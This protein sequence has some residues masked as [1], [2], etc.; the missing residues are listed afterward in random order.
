MY[1]PYKQKIDMDTKLL[2]SKLE[3]IQNDLRTKASSDE[4]RE[5]LTDLREK[6]ERIST[7]ETKVDELTKSVE[8]RDATVLELQKRLSILEDRSVDNARRNSELEHISHLRGRKVDDQEQ[9][10]RKVNLRIKGIPIKE[11]ET[12]TSLL[13]IVKAEC[14]R[15]GVGVVSGD[16]DHCHRNGK[17]LKDGN[18]SILLK[19][20]SWAARNQIYQ[21]RKEFNFK[22]SH[23][24]TARRQQLFTKA[25]E[26]LESDET[27]KKVVEYP[28]AD[29]NCKLKLK[30]KNGRY[31]HFNSEH[32]LLSLVQKLL[33]E[34]N[35]PSN[36]VEDEKNS[37]LY[38]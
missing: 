14:E 3:E 37:E 31:F 13:D 36:V 23:D 34:R 26:L 29:K 6:G 10:S 16:F 38:Y 11:D 17:V 4:L 33:D 9:V 12:T 21:N 1:K 28:L 2:L 25:N 5:V 19:M 30:A 32:E 15:V 18:Q 20:R 22:T 7:L 24:L 35:L 8:S 27:F